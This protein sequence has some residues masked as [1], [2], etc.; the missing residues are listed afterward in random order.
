MLLLKNLKNLTLKFLRIVKNQLFKNLY[1]ALLVSKFFKY[2]NILILNN[3]IDIYRA[4]NYW[5]HK[6]SIGLI[7]LSK[8]IFNP[9]DYVKMNFEIFFEH[10]KPKRDDVVVE[11]GAGEGCETLFISKLIGDKG[12]I[13]S[14]EPFEEIFKTLKETIKLNVL[15]N[16]VVIQKAIFKETSKIGFSSNINSWL[17]GK[18]DNN[19]ENLIT[20]ICLNDLVKEENL[21]QINFCKIN[22]EGA[23]KYISDNSDDFF[24]ICENIAIEC[25][26]FLQ[27][28]EYKTFDIIREFLISKNYKVKTSNRNKFPSDSFYLYGSK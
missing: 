20:T 17:G 12:K 13:I 3:N 23:E 21:S 15:K 6:T 26:D 8:P 14:L 4:N 18:I 9:E 2:I 1:L 11:F 16:V 10:Y 19:S 25:H 22:I 27:V 28:E 24:D 5:I 7:P